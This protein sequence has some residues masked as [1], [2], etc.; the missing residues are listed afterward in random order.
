MC[1]QGFP[2]NHIRDSMCPII[3]RGSRAGAVQVLKKGFQRLQM[4]D[5]QCSGRETDSLRFTPNPR[6]DVI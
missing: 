3:I 4:C 6:N 5:K 2:Q 1:L